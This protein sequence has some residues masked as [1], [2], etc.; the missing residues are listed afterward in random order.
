MT[1][2][3]IPWKDIGDVFGLQQL[4]NGTKS[5]IRIAVPIGESPTRLLKKVSQSAN[6]LRLEKFQ[7]MLLVENQ[8][9]LIDIYKTR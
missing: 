8:Q 3:S 5:S 6:K 1:P 7:Y 2:A 9:F 4:A